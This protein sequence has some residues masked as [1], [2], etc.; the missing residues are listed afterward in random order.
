MKAVLNLFFLLSFSLT[1]VAGECP[2]KKE[3]ASSKALKMDLKAA[4]QD[5]LD[6]LK[7][8]QEERVACVGLSSPS[9]NDVFLASQIEQ[10]ALNMSPPKHSITS[11]LIAGKELSCPNSTDELGVVIESYVF[12]SRDSLGGYYAD[13]ESSSFK[14]NLVMTGE[15]GERI[16]SGFEYCYG[17][18][19]A[20]P[21]Y[22]ILLKYEE[23]SDGK[24]PK[25]KSPGYD[26]SKFQADEEF[27]KC[28]NRKIY[29]SD[30]RPA[31]V[32]PSSLAGQIWGNN[33]STKVNINQSGVVQNLI[34]ENDSAELKQET[35][36]KTLTENLNALS[37]K[38]DQI[39]SY[40]GQDPKCQQYNL[41]GIKIANQL[42]S[43]ATA[44][45]QVM[46]SPWSGLA[47][48]LLAKP[49][50][51]LITNIG[52]RK[53]ESKSIDKAMEFL[54][55]DGY[56]NNTQL[57]DDAKKFPTY[58]CLL[59]KA[60]ESRCSDTKKDC[61]INTNPGTLTKSLEDLNS[62][63][64][65][66]RVSDSKDNIAGKLYDQ[67]F[68][69]KNSDGE[70]IG[71][72]M[73]GS[74][75]RISNYEYL[76]GVN[77]ENDNK[78]GKTEEE[79]PYK[80]TSILKNGL[81]DWVNKFPRDFTLGQNEIKNKLIEV[82]NEETKTVDGTKVKLDK[83][84]GCYESYRK[85]TKGGKDCTITELNKL[86]DET[87]AEMLKI[88][89]ITELNKSYLKSM[90]NQ[91]VKL[92]DSPAKNIET[93]IVQI[94]FYE[95][96]NHTQSSLF[97]MN[98][99][100]NSQVA[101]NQNKNDIDILADRDQ[102]F[103][104]LFHSYNDYSGKGYMQEYIVDANNTRRIAENKL[105]H[106][107][108]NT[109]KTPVKLNEEYFNLNIYPIIRDCVIGYQLNLKAKD[110]IKSMRDDYK[111]MCSMLK[112]CQGKTN[113]IG[114]P[115]SV[116]EENIAFD[117]SDPES[118]DVVCRAGQSYDLI[119]SRAKNEFLRNQ[120]ICGSRP[121]DPGFYGV[122]K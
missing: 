15:D 38:L 115:F 72:P 91:S 17:E 118:F 107:E 30:N 121:T 114:L 22:A 48:S 97:E 69:L 102:N 64:K 106:K 116:N 7:K 66:K 108:L 61:E 23:P 59:L 14:S 89:D 26:A 85:I 13:P 52:S 63:L 35:I 80:L 47:A 51:N 18:I 44:A 1:A 29:G 56:S 10:I 11:L 65:E 104:S 71:I 112:N 53:K 60:Q 2:Y 39:T 68:K 24:A 3:D 54:D 32:Q 67:M 27:K 81:V 6:F 113:S 31:K 76:F 86:A 120:S 111:K 95:L 37:E 9:D 58:A 77:E 119:M 92:P 34:N 16:N 55:G 83:F 40:A 117:P 8:R 33:C 21:I 50:Q 25:N 103:K 96:N 82:K 41:I 46:G 100:V 73:P 109:S 45:A 99:A 74:K 49:M 75:D 110:G 90:L 79:S 101:L 78:A 5:D 94:S 20:N 87:Q 98:D 12:N 84:K 105:A 36:E 62:V 43:T 93:G 4:F 28:I 42:I 70:K 19:R 57:N 88:G 122:E